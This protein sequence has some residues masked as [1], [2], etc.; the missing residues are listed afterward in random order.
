[1]IGR[2]PVGLE[3]ISIDAWVRIL[4]DVNAAWPIPLRA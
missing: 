2:A 1:M 3:A 4:H